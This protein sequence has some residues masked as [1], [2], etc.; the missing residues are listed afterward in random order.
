MKQSWVKG[1]L[2]EN[3][4]II[5]EDYVASAGARARLV[6]ILMDKIRVST[7]VK[8]QKEG[9]LSANWAYAQADT[10]GYER[11]IYEVISLISDISE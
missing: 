1:V 11:A 8:L 4:A 3:I 5:K 6:D 10:I 9:Y 7:T 2:A